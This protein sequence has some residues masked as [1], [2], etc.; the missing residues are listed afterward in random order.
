LIFPRKQAVR[1][2]FVLHFVDHA[3]AP[4][5]RIV[6]TGETLDIAVRSMCKR[7]FFSFC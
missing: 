6:V 5:R 3:A 7:R 1:V 2:V 4:D